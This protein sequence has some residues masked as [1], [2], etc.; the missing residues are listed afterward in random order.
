M[1]ITF[2]VYWNGDVVA[3]M[4]G[5]VWADVLDITNSEKYVRG[6]RIKSRRKLRV[7]IKYAYSNMEAYPQRKPMFAAS[8]ATRKPSRRNVRRLKTTCSRW[9]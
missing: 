7:A 2:V 5:S 9:L 8:S 1:K 6:K 3:E 4:Q